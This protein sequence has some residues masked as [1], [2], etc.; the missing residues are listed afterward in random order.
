MRDSEIVLLEGVDGDEDG[1]GWQPAL[2]LDHGG[3]G[4]SELFVI[5]GEEVTGMAEG[6]TDEMFEQL[7]AKLA[8]KQPPPYDPAD[9]ESHLEHN[10]HW[11]H[12]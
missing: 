11:P 2:S 6:V 3:P 5:V 9:V 12:G 4:H 8:P 10:P 1:N 7:R